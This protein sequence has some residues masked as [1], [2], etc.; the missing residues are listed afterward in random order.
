MNRH[1]LLFLF[2]I[3]LSLGG[4]SP[5]PPA[6][7]AQSNPSVIVSPR[8]ASW[9][10]RL[11]ARE[12]RRYVYLRTGRLLPLKT[13]PQ[14]ALPKGDLILVARKDR[15]LAR[16][17]ASPELLPTLDALTPQSYWLKS[18][19]RGHAVA[20]AHA[21]LVSGGDDAGTLYAACRLAEVLGVR[22]YL[23][24]DVLPDKQVE[25]SLPM[26]DERGAPLFALRGIQ[27]FHDFP[28]GPDWWDR[29]DYLAIIGQLPKL[30]L[31]FFGLHTY[32]EGHPNAEPTVW[33]GLA[34]DIAEGGKVKFS[35]P[36]SYMNTRRGNWGYAPAKTSDYIFGSAALFERDDFGPEVMRD[37]LPAPTTPEACNEVFD[38]TAG[39]L[40][41]A[42]TFAHQ[43]GVK[44]CVGTETPL[45]VPKLVQE[46]LKAQGR[47]PADPGALQDLYEGIFR[48]AAAAYPLDYY[49]FWTP[50]GWTWSAVKDEQIR[51][52]TND[53]AAAIAAWQRAR[54]P[55][56]LAT[57]GWVL[58]PQQD[59]AMFDK[60]LP[61]SVA[62]S[63]I[64]R[65][66]GYTP[67]D[68][69]FA[70]VRGRSK[71]AI[72]WLEDDG[73]MT[74]P[75]L[76]AGRMRRDAYDALRYGCDG[77]MGIHWRT[78]CLSPNIGALAQAAWEQ[79][80]WTEA[81]KPAPPAPA[82]PRVAGPVGGEVAGFPNNPIADTT[83]PAIYQTVRYNLSAYHL[84]ATNGPCTVTL[85]FCE[86]HYDAPGVRVFDVKL[87]GQTVLK[88]LDI[89]AKVGKNR[90]LDY[91]YTNVLV[92][93]GWLNIDF[94]PRVEFPSIA[95]IS[96]EG[97]GFSWKL[98][99]G[100]PAVAGYAADLPGTQLP[101]PVAPNSR[102]FYADWAEQ[103]FGHGIGDAAAAI[104]ARLDGAMPHPCNWVGGPGGI[105]PDGRP[106]AEVKRDYAFVDQFE[107]LRLGAVG[108]GNRERY[109]YWFHTFAYLRAVG[110][111][112]CAWGEYN[113]VFERV[114]QEKDATAQRD[115][116]R[117]LA[118]PLRVK[119]VELLG[120]V[121]DHLLATVTT[122]GELGTVMNWNQ[123]ILP[124]LLAKPGE[125]LAN[126]LGEPLPANALPGHSYR[127]PTRIIVPTTRT[128][129]AANEALKLKVIVLSEAPPRE[130]AL[131]W[132]KLGARRFA[133]V[134]LKWVARGVYSVQVPAG[135]KDDFEYYIRVQPSQGQPVLYPATAPR[136]NQ[137][138]VITHP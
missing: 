102:D 59:R 124:G 73:A 48:R 33:I 106:W 70:E 36:S 116:A 98:N 75:Q 52:T 101:K 126:L 92:A 105:Q 119:L 11:A 67:V 107:G 23:H 57:C 108:P 91:T 10:E 81:Y 37:Y 113:R 90:A 121:F 77:L 78:R 30:R 132:R 122:T 25:W 1:S 2:G 8:D 16:T 39:M 22:F 62:V 71:W 51:A 68:A 72:P 34:S 128:S 19:P 60:A 53:L 134:P 21:L 65:Q 66:V 127:G 61:K 43:V 103:H 63:C 97:T 18:Q 74:A 112:N 80:A 118:L 31:N 82:P 76:W 54:V 95:A 32:P 117:R 94:V 99:C 85:K 89:F 55:F 88:G 64:N 114:K 110:E 79:G 17:A 69:G 120:A 44:T 96:V 130:G 111:L 35:Y 131:Y 138:V 42:F 104:F 133:Q 41:E 109:D 26:L 137:T 46:R 49:W 47:D 125:E 84:P 29:D 136:L 58:G 7:A 9:M 28:E 135:A 5:V 4:I 56:S 45:T 27:P 83:T 15:S 93:D 87:Q 6:V 129:L 50:E 3:S 14:G 38:R 86:P 13:E 12:V 40:R 123:H 20:G 24:G 100:G 115:M